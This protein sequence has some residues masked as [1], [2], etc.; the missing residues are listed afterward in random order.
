MRSMLRDVDACY[1]ATAT[2]KASC[3]VAEQLASGR[4]CCCCSIICQRSSWL[5]SSGR[6][7]FTPDRPDNNVFFFTLFYLLD[8]HLL[9]SLWHGDSWMT[10]CPSGF[11]VQ[12]TQNGQQLSLI[13]SCCAWLLHHKTYQLVQFSRQHTMGSSSSKVEATADKVASKAEKASEKTSNCCLQANELCM[14]LFSTER[15]GCHATWRD[16]KA[17]LLITHACMH[18]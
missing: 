8:Q 11:E 16:R 1:A 7:T 14:R 9:P 6:I 17:C 10:V 4:R 2:Q 13:T 5:P 3:A 18:L 12:R 15:P